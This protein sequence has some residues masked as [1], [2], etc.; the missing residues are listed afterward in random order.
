MYDETLAIFQEEQQKE[1]GHVGTLPTT[2][3][4]PR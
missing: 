3:S 1:H 2:L 4:K